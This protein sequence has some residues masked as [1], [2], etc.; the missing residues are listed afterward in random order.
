M[1][2]DVELTYKL[3]ASLEYKKVEYLEYERKLE[4]LQRN[5]KISTIN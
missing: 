2:C 5:P 4:T 3:L 1:R